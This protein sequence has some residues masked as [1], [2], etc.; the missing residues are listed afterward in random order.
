MRGGVGVGR[1]GGCKW[2]GGGG[3]I[4]NTQSTRKAVQWQKRIH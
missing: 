2:V 3:G 4:Y 1:E